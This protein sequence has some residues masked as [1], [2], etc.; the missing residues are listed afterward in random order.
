M[1]SA[2][3]TVEKQKNLVETNQAARQRRAEERK[4]ENAAIKIQVCDKNVK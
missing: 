4:R 1:F 3:Q 2:G